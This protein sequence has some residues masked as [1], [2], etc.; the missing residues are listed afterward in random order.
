MQKAVLPFLLLVSSTLAQ[1]YQLQ[2]L[3]LGSV[4][5]ASS[6]CL[7]A[8]NA[9]V[10]CPTEIGWLYG[11]PY[12]NLGKSTLQSLCTESCR[13]SLQAHRKAIAN[14]CTAGVEYIDVIERTTY[15]PTAL[16]DQIIFAYNAA[17][18]K[19]S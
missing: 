9:N 8:I 12:Q 16:D 3:S 13:S 15:L 4:P 10:G 2:D 1:T 19:K 14:A 6:A 18:L 5:G 17:C 7:D 11:N